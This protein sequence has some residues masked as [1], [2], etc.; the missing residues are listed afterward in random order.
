MARAKVDF[1]FSFLGR[2]SRKHIADYLQIH[3]HMPSISI[4]TEN[5]LHL[6]YYSLCEFEP[7]LIFI[8]KFWE[9]IDLRLD[10]NLQTV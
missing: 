6:I 4:H 8:E 2:H 3:L 1:S 5:G 7:D 10:S 9:S